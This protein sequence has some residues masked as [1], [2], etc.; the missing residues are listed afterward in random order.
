M[1]LFAL[2]IQHSLLW[3]AKNTNKDSGPWLNEQTIR[4][5]EVLKG[6]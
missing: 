1:N 3:Y 6:V 2:F 5:I 4:L